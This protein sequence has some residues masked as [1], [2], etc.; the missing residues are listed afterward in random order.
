VFQ[1]PLPDGLP[2]MKKEVHSIPTEPSHLPPFWQMYRLSPLKYGEL[3]KHVTAFLKVGILEMST[4]S[5]DA[6][7]LFVS[8]PNGKGLRLCVDYRALNAVTIKNHCTIPM[9]D[10]LLDAVS[11]SKYF[12]SFDLT[13]GY[14]QILIFEEDR[15][16]TV[17]HT[18]FGHFQFK[19]LIEG[20]M[21]AP[22]TFQTAMN[23]IFHPYL[24]KFVVV[25]FD[26]IL[27]YS[28]IEEEHKAHV[29]LVL[30]VLKR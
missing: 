23:S 5:H 25:F 17:F 4:S 1:D 19:V 11:G 29:R 26:D 12:T 13:T 3:E 15:P 24:R 28:H 10:D 7:V 30:D 22:V 27:I 14:H 21:N 9:I 2:P 18:P 20:L 6:H 16:K 8:M